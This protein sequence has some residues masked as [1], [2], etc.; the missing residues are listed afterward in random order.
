ME[1]ILAIGLAF[2]LGL[3]HFFGEEIDEYIMPENLFLASFS[4]GLTV[5]YF[6]LGMLPEIINAPTNLEY[7]LLF[8]LVGFSLFYIV[9][10][11]IY[12]R[13]SNL[14]DVKKEFKELHSF[15]IF[16]YHFV[17]GFLIYF[18]IGEGLYQVLLFYLP[19]FVHTA[20]NSLA[21]KEMNEEMLDK[22]WIKLSASFASV[23]GVSVSYLIGVSDFVSYSLFGFIGG[24]F[25][26]LVVHDALDPQR[27]RPIG[28]ITGALVFSMIV[29]VL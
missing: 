12:E 2:L 27:E 1:L 14:S 21:I 10:E 6:L 8:A 25:L 18:L 23:L 4:A 17:L 26:Y 24:M 28:F 20:V 16:S 19:V 3:V 22:A 5:S 7:N 11:I 9:E 15:F 29:F 13:E